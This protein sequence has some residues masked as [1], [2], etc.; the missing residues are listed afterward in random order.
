MSRLPA[1]F[2]SHGAPNLILANEGARDFL[3]GYGAELG[4]PQAILMVSAHFET[5]RPTLTADARPAMIYDFHGFEDALYSI[6]YPAPGDPAFAGQVAESLRQQGF[7]PELAHDRGFD[8]GAWVP[9]KLLYPDADIPVVQLSVQTP[10]GPDHHYRLGRALAA[11]RD[12]NVLVIGSGSMTHNLYELRLGG[13]HRDR[14]TPDWVVEFGEWMREKAEA[15]ALD[16]LLDYRERAPHAV[17]NH[18]SEEHLLPFFVALGAGGQGARA[19]RVHTSHSYGVLQMD[20][21]RFN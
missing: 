9:L 3:A 6:T 18:P 10:L 1:L 20:A 2:V 19:E 16:D 8:H 11:L 17:R 7:E 21:Y 13:R 12:D 14:E 5:D 4:R 15:G